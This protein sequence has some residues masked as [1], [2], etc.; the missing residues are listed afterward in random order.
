[1]AKPVW[2]S[3]Q[4]SNTSLGTFIERQTLGVGNVPFINLLVSDPE[5]RSNLQTNQFR[6][7]VEKYAT[8]NDFYIKSNGLTG[9]PW[10]GSPEGYNQYRPKEQSY[11]F[12]FPALRPPLTQ[13]IL[14]VK[15]LGNIGVAVNGVPLRSPNSGKVW[16]LADH[17]YTEN[18]VIYPVQD[19]FTDGSGIIDS[20]GAFYY[21]TNP[22]LLNATH[23]NGH[24]KIIG[25]AFDGLPVYGP[26]GYSDP[27]NSNSIIRVIKSSY[28]L[29]QMLRDDD[30]TPDGTFIEDFEYVSNLGDLD[31][32]NSRHCKTPDYPNG[33]RAYFVTVDPDDITL[34]RYP[35]IIGP[36]YW[37]DP[38]I[39]NGRFEWPEK[40]DVSIISGKLP[41]GLRIEGLKIVGT[42][43]AVKG[44]ITSKFVLRAR[45]LQG[46]A[47]RTFTI[48]I[49]GLGESIEWT[50]PTGSL[51]VG[52]NNHF[53]ILDNSLIDFQL[54]AIDKDLPG[55][56][57]LNYHI[58]P[59][60]GELPGGISLSRSGKLYGFTAPI[61]AVDVTG[62]S[63]KYDANLYDK[64]GYDYA[65]RPMNGYDSFF[66]DIPTFD[67]SSLNRAPK[68]LNRYYQFKVRASDGVNFVDRI[69]KIYVVGDDYLRSDN[70]I[71]RVGTNTFSADNTYMRKAIWI[72]KN[73]IGKI[74]ANNYVTIIL[75]V[76]D[77]ATLEGSIG[78]ILET[79]NPEISAKPVR[80]VNSGSTVIKVK[81]YSSIPETGMKLAFDYTTQVTYTITNVERINTN[82]IISFKLT[83]N[84][85]I[86]TSFFDGEKIEIGATITG[87]I[88][89]FTA[90]G[91]TILTIAEAK[92]SSLPDTTRTTIDIDTK[93]FVKP[94]GYRSSPAYIYT[95]TN[96]QRI[97]ENNNVYYNLTLNRPLDSIVNVRTEIKIGSESILPPGMALDSVSGELFGSVPYQPAISKTYK[98]TINALRYSVDT[99]VPNVPSLRTFTVDLIGNID[100]VIHFNTSGDLGSISANFI[101]NIS[102]NAVTTVPYAV[103]TYNLASG[104][105]PPGLT[106]FNDGTI[107]GKVSQFS[108]TSIGPIT[109]DLLKTTFDQGSTSFN[110]NY[111]VIKKEEMGLIT[112]DKNTMSFDKFKTTFDR[113]Y[114]FTVEARDQFAESAV[115]K[116]FKLSIDT[117]N[118]KLYSNIYVKPFLKYDMR[119]KLVEFFSDTNV[120][121]PKLIYR[122]SDPEFGIQNTLKM[123]LY[124]GIESKTISNYISA[125]GRAYRK[126]YRIGN[127]KKAIAK[128]PGTNDILYELVYLEILDNQE[129][130]RGSVS[131]FINTSMLKHQITV[132]Q[133]K[134]DIIDSDLTDIDINTMSLDRLSS[135]TIQDKV[136]T[137][138]FSGQNVSDL[139]RSN[140]YG[141]STINM[142]KN[143]EKIGDTERNF[144]PLWMRTPQ[145][146][147]GVE[148]GFTK[149]IPLCY[150]VPGYADNMI[151]NI[152]NS[153]FD[154]KMIDFTVDRAIIDSVVG[155]TGDKYI[156]FGAREVING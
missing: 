124:P 83:L 112:Y 67:F 39:P 105:L 133:G 68:K 85:P 51:P 95:I 64:Y 96:A 111:T 12:K 113:S 74:R 117:P 40:I 60:G 91:S 29:K 100:S 130:E 115:T 26:F 62:N 61:L 141:N 131:E 58:P 33:T 152:K 50:T 118:N 94:L 148:Q 142:R 1:M 123:L 78:Y 144:L 55:G 2:S 125:F 80:A 53:Y 6:N 38:M 138:D 75:D 153:R 101:S 155:D 156:A 70:D 82:G 14:S 9:T 57:Y 119:L 98:F 69:F 47:D 84:K 73:Y 147:S 87:K 140:V 52:A 13:P 88:S 31:E 86:E 7:N 114:T 5:N 145:S 150:C 43:F 127:L 16:N 45:N 132:N 17:D 35:Y 104:K 34:P 37:G 110:Q 122:S 30:T 19:Y 18:S 21:Q 76:F 93:I 22:T 10:L 128:T 109:F 63:G 92:D 136:I 46:I 11:I 151:L 97:V 149:A 146:F 135:I 90:A 154:F 23:P 121:E 42:P 56:K 32:F 3:T 120:F 48:K 15:A 4:P 71:L 49:G 44:S 66:Y 25:Y 129:N 126:R 143:I 65:V 134:R 103:L 77:P 24:S 20:D 102:V 54:D 106:L 137:A 27:D 79:L 81:D 139:N 107:Q 41:D 108:S 116:T 8:L 89:G 72:T 36:D 99:S 59:N 28:R